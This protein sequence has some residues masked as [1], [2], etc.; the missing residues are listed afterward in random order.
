MVGVKYCR[1]DTRVVVVT[2]P[3]LAVIAGDVDIGALDG[4]ARWGRQIRRGRRARDLVRRA[5]LHAGADDE[6]VVELRA[7]L[8]V[9]DRVGVDVVRALTVLAQAAL[10]DHGA[11]A[12]IEV[13]ADT[14]LDGLIR[15]LG[16]GRSRY[17]HGAQGARAQKDFFH[18]TLLNLLC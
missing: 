5:E 6:A 4:V 17:G 12:G 9:E 7:A 2:D 8:D 18:V 13:T 1:R 3:D 14:Q 10:A 11:V 15:R 16:E